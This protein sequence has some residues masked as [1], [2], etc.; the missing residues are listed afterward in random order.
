MIQAAELAGIRKRAVR[1]SRS[2]V[3]HREGYASGFLVAAVSVSLVACLAMGMIA[4]Q[5]SVAHL[6]YTIV[7][8]KAELRALEAE[9]QR[10]ELEIARLSSLE[11]VEREAAERLGMCRADE[12]RKVALAVRPAEP[13]IPGEITEDFWTTLAGSILGGIGRASAG[14]P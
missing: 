5:N 13:E 1:V 4:S 8:M 12:V 11:R 2:R 9:S 10:L 7:E 3:R 14:S 6:G